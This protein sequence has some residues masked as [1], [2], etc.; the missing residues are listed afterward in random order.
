[1]E[2]SRDNSGA[3]EVKLE[4]AETPQ[5]GR[6]NVE[7]AKNNQICDSDEDQRRIVPDV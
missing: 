4:A 5:E 2:G 7:Q 6:R 1:M 3:G